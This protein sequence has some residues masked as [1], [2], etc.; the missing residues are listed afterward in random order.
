M[1][2]LNSVTK[3]IATFNTA[4]WE[5]TVL[6]YLASLA[7]RKNE[8]MWKTCQFPLRKW[9]HSQKHCQVS[10]FPSYFHDLRQLVWNLPEFGNTKQTIISSTRWLFHQMSPWWWKISSTLWKTLAVKPTSEPDGEMGTLSAGEEGRPLSMSKGSSRR[11]LF[12]FSVSRSLISPEPWLWP[13]ARVRTPDKKSAI[14]SWRS[15]DGKSN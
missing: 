15:S 3:K 7:L 6:H 11:G 5:I 9:A 8:G 1:L 10:Y 14:S 13:S 4:V 2:I 12:F